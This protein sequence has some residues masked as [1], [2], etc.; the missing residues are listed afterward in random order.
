MK[1]NGRHLLAVLLTVGMIIGNMSGAVYADEV[2]PSAASESVLETET[3]DTADEIVDS[4]EIQSES[5]TGETEWDETSAETEEENT[6]ETD[7]E[8]ETSESESMTVQETSEDQ[9]YHIT[10]VKKISLKYDDRYAFDEHEEFAG[11]EIQ[12][13]EDATVDSYKVSKGIKTNSK[14]EHVLISGQDAKHDIIAAGTGSAKVILV[15]EKTVE[16][17]DASD[18]SDTAEQASDAIEVDISVEAAALT[19]M[20]LTGQSNME[21]Y[22]SD[23]IGYHPEDSVVCEAGQ[24][25]ST[26]VP[27]NRRTSS[28]IGNVSFG[29]VCTADNAESFVAGSLTGEQAADGSSLIYPLNALTE[30]GSGKTGMDGA[31][32]YEWHALSNDKIWVINTAYSGTT[33]NKWLPGNMCYE[34]AKAVYKLAEK[35][36]D[37][38]IKAGHYVSGSRLMFWQQ[39]ETDGLV[40]TDYQTYYA[41]FV[42]MYEAFQSEF[43]IDKCGIIVSR[44]HTGS[45]TDAE[46]IVMTGARMAQYLLAVDS[47]QPD[48]YMVSNVNEEWVSDQGVQRY[49]QE[50]YLSGRFTYPLRANTTL[51]GLPSAV[52]DIHGGVHYAQA[53]HNENGLTAAKCMYQIKQNTSGNPSAFWKNMEGQTVEGVQ[54]NIGD[55]VPAVPEVSPLYL[56]KKIKF[57][58]DESYLTSLNRNGTFTAINVGETQIKVKNRV[59]I[60]VGALQVDISSLPAPKLTSLVNENKKTILKWHAVDHAQKYIVYR[61]TANSGWKRLGETKKEAFTDTNVKHGEQYTYTV[62][63]GYNESLGAYDQKGMSI[64][65]MDMPV[66]KSISNMAKGINIKWTAINGADKYAVFRKQAGGKWSRIGLGGSTSFTDTSAEDG[67]QYIY[68]IVARKGSN[69]SGYDRNGQSIYRLGE[70]SVVIRGVGKNFIDVGWNRIK[71]ADGYYIYRKTGRNGWQRI[72]SVSGDKNTSYSDKSVSR[73]QHYYYTV[74]AYKGKTISTYSAGQEAW[75]VNQPSA[76]SK[77]SAVKSE[78][79]A[80]LSWTAVDDASGYGIYMRE[81]GSETWKTVKA[82]TTGTKY[83]VKNLEPGVKYEFM[84]RSYTKQGKMKAYGKYS[85]I[86]SAVPYE[87]VPDKPTGL[88]AAAGNQS[89]TLSWKSAKNATGYNIFYYDKNTGNMT[90][91]GSTRS[92]SCTIKNLDNGTKYSFVIRSYRQCDS[93]VTRSG[94]TSAVTAVPDMRK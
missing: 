89:I 74:R 79:R 78:C 46:D 64:V 93:H 40:G 17:T 85:K 69:A 16:E 76:V 65:Y 22:S 28:E 61:K 84:V 39:G 73:D 19:V 35:T 42:Q 71:D 82:E 33:I 54:C 9:S 1:G 29:S 88:S 53:A 81:S 75:C 7:F 94:Y 51:T 24:V 60:S 48:I 83:T 37:A 21:G 44:A 27:T 92:S 14:D 67:Q 68:T 2:Q 11:Y 32:A 56:S 80:E 41:D 23:D 77:V 62:R 43:N 55:R 90:S 50:T 6:E 70:P 72:A 63:A 31:L 91:A 47:E 12:R 18:A 20:F 36:L 8:Q 13:I 52:D 3:S 87:I 4:E 15:P 10:F 49:F 59:G 26:Y 58:V 5:D 57:K 86:V 30:E 45:E 38:E 34:R 25:Y 66:I